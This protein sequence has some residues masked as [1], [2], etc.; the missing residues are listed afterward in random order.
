[1]FVAEI[2]PLSVSVV[3]PLSPL[4]M[5]GFRALRASEMVV[6][7]CCNVLAIGFDIWLIISG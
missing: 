4:T 7:A 6:E 5:N 3:I 1:M 2:P